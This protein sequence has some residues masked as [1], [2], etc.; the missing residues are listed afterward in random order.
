MRS[1]IANKGKASITSLRSETSRPATHSRPDTSAPDRL[2]L[3]TALNL[4]ASLFSIPRVMVTEVVN[5]P[6]HDDCSQVIVVPPFV[7]I[8]LT[9]WRERIGVPNVSR[10]VFLTTKDLQG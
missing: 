7:Y 2:R 4:P 5:G 10:I 8:G 3:S 6:K 1:G 9:P